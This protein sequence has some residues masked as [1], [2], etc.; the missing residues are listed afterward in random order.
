MSALRSRPGPVPW[1]AATRAAVALAGPL[2][3][4]VATDHVSYGVLVA[5]GALNGVMEDRY[6]SY[7]LRLVRM[8]PPQLAGAVG[9]VVGAQAAGRGWTT[10][11]VLVAVAL[12]SG[13]I[14]PIGA[15][16]SSC[17]LMLLLLTVVGTGVP[18]P[19]PWWLPP[20][21]LLSGGLLVV[22]LALLAWPLRRGAPER[23]AVAE[24]YYAAAERLRAAGGKRAS[25]LHPAALHA[26]ALR[27]SRD[28]SAAIDTAYDLLVRHR[29]G[30]PGRDPAIQHLMTQL[31]AVNPILEASAALAHEPPVD[32]VFA[33]AI[34]RLGDAVAAGR[35][36]V[37]EP[38]FEPRTPAEEAL[39][40]AL[41][42]AAGRLAPPPAGET[43]VFARDPD[44]LGLPQLAWGPRAG[45]RHIGTVLTG[46]TAWLYGLRLALC[47]GIASVLVQVA[48][49]PRS[50]WV[51]LTITFV[52]K[53][54][55]GSVFVRG[56][57]RA[58]GTLAGVLVA[59]VLLTVVPRGWADVA[60]VAVLAFLVPIATAR[61]YGMQTAAI[62]PLM[63]LFTD[64]L[65]H[66]G[67]AGLV[68]ARVVDTLLGCAI[69]LVFGYLLWPDG[70]RTRLRRLV[71]ET[72]EADAA[73]LRLV[74]AEGPG[75]KASRSRARRRAYNT[76]TKSRTAFQQAL[77]EPP[78]TSRR[79]AAFWPVLVS[80]ERLTDSIVAASAYLD[81]GAEPL[82]QASVDRYADRIAALAGGIRT[83][84]RVDDRP[85]GEG[86]GEGDSSGAEAASAG[87][88]DPPLMRAVAMEIHTACGLFDQALEVLARRPR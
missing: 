69:V 31:N 71:A 53:P 37:A 41:R 2:A 52:L 47:V 21:L 62:T 22:A 13:V 56:V 42:Y 70:R 3:V 10:V 80:V 59:A 27:T 24:V 8:I 77:A 78:P 1:P 66:Q 82:D 18:L 19:E 35:E 40:S 58:L 68:P 16:A 45:L 11:A 63:L 32:P 6:A 64:Q 30:S 86:Q 50:Y 74:L 85:G 67:V 44:G 29:A 73:Y 46:S 57:L 79:A 5:L 9:I 81:G 83:G 48:E 26:S 65:G 14:S 7:R 34:T 61:S 33:D 60:V 17:G 88:A 54:D 51:A 76:L 72:V 38:G 36:V 12:L 4:G 15:I 28:I 49:L 20:V 87:D 23:Q 84:S 25:E 55:F 39:R 75:G 43:G